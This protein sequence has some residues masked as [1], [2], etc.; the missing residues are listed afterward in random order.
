MPA[1]L[2]RVVALSDRFILIGLSLAGTDMRCARFIPASD[3]AVVALVTGILTSATDITVYAVCKVA[4]TDQFMVVANLNGTV[5]TRR[6]DSA[7]VLQVPSGGQYATQV[8]AATALAIEASS[9][10]NQVTIGMVV[11][12]EAR[13]F[14][15]NLTTGADIGVGPHVPFSGETSTDVALV[16]QSSTVLAVVSSVTS[17]TAPTVFSRPYT[18]ST[19][20]FGTL[21]RSVTDAT[22]A[23][24]PAYS[25]ELFI[26]IRYGASGVGGSANIIVSASGVDNED[27]TPQIVKDLE[28][29]GGTSALLPDVAL[30]SSTG[31]YYWANAAAK[32]DGALTP[33]L[34]EFSLTST[35]RRQTAQLGNLAYIAGGAPLVFDGLTLTESGFQER[36]RIISLTGSNGSGQLLSGGTYRYRIHWEWVD[37]DGN[38]HLSPPSAITSITLGAAE[39]TVDISCSTPHSMRRNSGAPSET[40]NIVVSRTLCTVSR[41]AAVITGLVSIS[42]PSG[43]LNGLTLLIN[44][45]D[46]AI[47]TVTFGAGDTTATAILATINAVTTTE[48]TATAP[49]GLLVLTS[50]D[51]GDTAILQVLGSGTANTILGFAGSTVD[52]GETTVTVGE[53]FQRSAS[54]YT[55]S[56]AAVAAYKTVTDTRKDQSDPIVDTDLI[57]QQVLYSSGVAS[58]A[59]HAPPPGD[60]IAAGR[61]RIIV[62]RQ[63]RGSRWTASKLAAPTEPAEFA[64]TGFESYS[65]NVAG[66]I[67]A[68]TVLGD[69]IIAFTRREIWEVSGSGP[70]RNGIGEFFAPRRISKAGGLVEDGWRSLVETDEG[71]YF[72]RKS[73]QLCF[74]AK[75]GAVEW[76]GQA[77]QDYLQLYPVVTA[78]TYVST[79][80]SVAFACQSTDGLTGGI[81]RLDIESKAWFFDDVG[82]V[83]SMAEYDGR[84]AYIQAGVVYLQDASPG[85]GT[86]VSYT[87]ETNMFQGF[88]ALGYGQANQVGFLGTWQGAC[89]V[90][91]SISDDGTTYEAIAAWS[92]TDSEYDANDRVVL[93]KVPAVQM[94]DSFAIRLAVTGTT[95]SRGVWLHAL[96]L[97]TTQSPEL[98]RK[99][100]AHNL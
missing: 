47:H 42:P 22:L 60:G 71:L 58:G 30:D 63:P 50:T 96:A 61:D 100:A 49:S 35:G 59:H 80:H 24:S 79:K 16:R 14:S 17:E 70:G 99:G 75:S 55:S 23:A 41:T 40:I 45:G 9:T 10:A 95:D 78:G 8:A 66:D 38:L 32:P 31:K 46:G 84:I 82:V 5:T 86:F 3:E 67:E 28:V 81:L 69:S 39:D 54:D 26:P 98:A 64:A 4:G 48:V 34:T 25:T 62:A 91:L 92:L 65:G 77:I 27:V 44:D 97:D 12:G 51:T 93:L 83:A 89:T 88:Q 43:V 19:N 56:T 52:V 11:A 85:S 29:S 90:T 2:M 36:P 94:R 21:D 7:G 37:S 74:L 1:R 53:N 33:L 68:V 57:R 73:D 13:L 20:A 72:Q 6:Y 87:V 15:Y 76:V 18:V